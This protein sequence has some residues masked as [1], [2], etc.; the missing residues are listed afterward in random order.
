MI[1]SRVE[2]TR[3]CI[4]RLNLVMPVKVR[5]MRGIAPTGY[6]R[7]TR[8]FKCARGSSLTENHAIR[9]GHVGPVASGG[10]G[11]RSR[12]ATEPPAGSS[13]QAADA[14]ARGR[15]RRARGAPGPGPRPPRAP[16]PGG[17]R[18]RDSRVDSR[19][20]RGSRPPAGPA[21]VKSPSGAR[22]AVSAGRSL[23]LALVIRQR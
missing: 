23:L 4:L 11:S 8:G 14:A 2:R 3:G 12:R 17:D 22:R 6:P 10:V 20:R 15:A 16:P 21:C 1:V 19:D 7:F 5:L 13:R 18:R 9:P